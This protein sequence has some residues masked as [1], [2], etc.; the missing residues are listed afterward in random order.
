MWVKNH[1]PGNGGQ[2]LLYMKSIFTRSQPSHCQE[3]TYHY[4]KS[5]KKYAFNQKPITLKMNN[6]DLGVVCVFKGISLQMM[7]SFKQFIYHIMYVLIA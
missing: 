7:H 2:G 3:M 5:D 1:G 4:T 6:S